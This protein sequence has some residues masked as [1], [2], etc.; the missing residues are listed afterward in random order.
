MIT[1]VILTSIFNQP[2]L[3]GAPIPN[4]EDKNLANPHGNTFAG[5]KLPHTIIFD[6]YELAKMKQLVNMKQNDSTVKNFIKEVITEADSVLI[7]RPI[8]VTEKNEVPP[9]GTKHDYFALASYEWPNPNTPNGLPYVSRDGETNPETLLIKDRVYLEEMV[10]RVMI[11]AIASYF[12]EDPKYAL[13]ADELLRVWFL[14]NDTYMNPSLKYGDFERGKGRLNP[15]GIM[16]AHHLAQL[17]DAIG[18]LEL[19]PKWS[20]STQVGLEKWFSRYLDWLLTSDQAKLEGQRTNN[21]G[22]YYTVQVSAIANFL[23]RSDVTKKLLKS[24]MQDLSNVPLEDVS[25][26]IT[27]KI[28]PDGTQP[29]EIRRANSLHYHIWNLYGVVLLARM[30]NQEGIDLWNYEIHGAGIRKAVDFI[31]PYA[32]GSQ[33]W[34]YGRIKQLTADDHEFLQGILCQAMLHYNVQSYIQAYR[35]LEAKNLPLNFQDYVC[36]LHIKYIE[37]GSPMN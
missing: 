29:F 32:M 31:I 36:D 5:E 27:V 19:S 23:N 24:T 35:I 15:S 1:F 13:K 33:S 25:R 30:A 26:L 9:N 14:D 6:P 12:T 8:S 22:T 37:S 20:E 2:T 28:N 18:I 21:H 11:L 4:P 10:D 7:K 16:G 17:V 34:P 3:L